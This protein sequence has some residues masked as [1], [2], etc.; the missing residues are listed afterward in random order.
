MQRTGKLRRAATG[1]GGEHLATWLL[2]PRAVVSVGITG[3]AGR[4]GAYHI[5]GS[6]NRADP[7]HERDVM[8]TSEKQARE[9]TEVYREYFVNEKLRRMQRAMIDGM[10]QMRRRR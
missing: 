6:H 8:A 10:R 1:K 3:K 7:K 4:V 5:K 9:Y 2:K